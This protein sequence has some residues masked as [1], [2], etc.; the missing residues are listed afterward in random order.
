MGVIKRQ[1]IKQSLVNYLAVVIGA[2]STIFIYPLD[3]ETLGLARF[4][5]DGSMFLA[6]FLMLGLNGVTIRFFPYFKD[7]EKRPSRFS[8]ALTFRSLTGE[9]AFCCNNADFP[10]LFL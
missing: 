6:P 9:P 4:I 8:A 5:I 2:I 7:E 3:T 10:G 1:G